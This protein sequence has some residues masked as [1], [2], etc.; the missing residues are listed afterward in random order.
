MGKTGKWLRNFL[1]GKKEKGKESKSGSNPPVSA[2]NVEEYH[3]PTTP[4]SIPQ[5]M[6]PKEKRRWSFRRSSAGAPG[7][8]DSSSVESMRTPSH[9]YM[10]N[11]DSKKHA[12]A[13]AAAT[14]AAAD[15]A[16]AAAKAA[17]A[18]IQLTAAA[19][20][21]KARDVEE[22]AATKIQSVFRAYLARKALN[23]LKGLVKLQALVRGH[24]VRKQ[25]TATLRRMQALMKVQIQARAQ[26]LQM[27]EETKFIAQ[28][29]FVPRKSN[30]E[31]K[32]TNLNQ[33]S[34][35]GI[36]E[37]IKIVEMDLGGYK[38]VTKARNSYSNHTQTHHRISTQ[39][40]QEYHQISPSPSAITD[41]SPRTYSNHFDNYSFSSP[42]CYSSKSNPNPARIP[43][44]YPRSEYAESESL[45]SF[46][47]GYMANTESS[48]AKVRSHSAPKQRP[49]ETFERQ[50]SRRRY[51][52]EGRNVPKAVRMQRSSSLVGSTTPSYQYPWSVK[53]DRSTVSL[54][55]SECG[56]TRTVRTN[57]NYCRSLV[58]FDVQG[59]RY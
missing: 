33:D 54:K 47:P 4:V 40:K 11:D 20:S 25:A 13:L 58:G 37:N 46:Y 41:I 56:S 42:Q 8:P 1:T 2:C 17:A 59:A 51:F 28:R 15:A 38:P 10:E 26:R 16:V 29:Q 50:T 14:A 32:F 12:L 22:A 43:F 52:L 23:A 48:K 57:T 36:E 6:T 49:V 39:I 7:R 44:A 53:I 21:G 30:H 35:K 27:S 24:L 31:N 55:D 34:D 3:Q 5:P 9:V 19:A 18:V 45:Y